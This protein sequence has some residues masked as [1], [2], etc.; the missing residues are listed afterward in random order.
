M[1]KGFPW[2]INVYLEDEDRVPLRLNIWCEV[3]FS[4]FGPQNTI[5][6][7][8]WDQKN[9]SPIASKWI[10]VDVFRFRRFHMVKP[11]DIDV[12]NFVILISTY[13]INMVLLYPNKCIFR[14]TAFIQIE[15]CTA[16]P[17]GHVKLRKMEFF[18]QLVSRGSG[19]PSDFFMTI[20]PCSGNVFS[21]IQSDYLFS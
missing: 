14:Q 3:I 12:T 18:L 16:G 1:K 5:K 6:M 21:N 17:Y 15:N 2:Y 10:E 4:G 7:P 13:E 9:A 20:Q 8:W 19:I 11:S